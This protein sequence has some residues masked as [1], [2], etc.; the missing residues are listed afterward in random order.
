MRFYV[1]FEE[2]DV[3][4]V[5]TKYTA[6][7]NAQILI[8]LL[9]DNGIKKIVASPGTTNIA[10]V[11]SVQQDDFFEVFSAPDERSASYIACGM[12]EEAQEPVV[13][14]CTG[15]TASRNYMPGLTEAF[16]RK[17]PIIA[18][19]SSR[20]NYY[21]GQN[22]DQVTDRTVLPNDIAKVSVQLPLVHDL[23]SEWA[24]IVRGNKAMHEAIRH[25]GGPV[26]INLE[27]K[28]NLD[29]SVDKIAPVRNIEY[30]SINSQM[31]EVEVDEVG[32]VVGSHSEWS[33]ELTE[34][35]DTFCE[36]YNGAVICDPTSNYMGKYKIN[37][38]LASAQVK[39][40]SKV[41]KIAHII[42]IGG[43][44]S[45]NYRINPESVW[46]V[47]P[48]G[49]IRDTYKH[50]KAIFELDECVFFKKYIALKENLKSEMNLYKR[51]KE[52]EQEIE[53]K[54]YELPFSNAWIASNYAKKLPDNAILHLGIR[55]SLRVWSFFEMPNRVRTYSNVG[56]FGI[57]GCISS[58]IGAALVN[59]E[60]LVFCVLG[61]LAFFYDMNSLGNRHVSSN[62]RIMLVNN[63]TGMEMK[64]TGFY[65]DAIGADK[66]SYIAAS[67]HYGNKSTTLVKNYA[68]NLGFKYF[69]AKSK[70]EFEKNAEAFFSDSID[71]QPYLFE[72][73][74]NSDDED[75]AYK[76]LI[77]LE[78]S[79]MGEMK[80]TIKKVVGNTK[81]QEIKKHIQ[82]KGK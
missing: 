46:R 76:K 42:H 18:V 57:D 48:D 35:V 7:R 3:V 34:L 52:E 49:E 70:E 21:I 47:S 71:E 72:V 65:A 25:G 58:S 19:T 38:A 73:F 30:Y 59:K 14:S 17:L 63:A 80:S 23:D 62:L 37:N 40:N 33:R 8:S 29:F 10:F 82:G 39:Y 64:F 44:T 24:C 61:D 11:A 51:L 22:Y 56:G 15:A 31:P 75:E 54:R 67:N 53:S 20:Q 55:N 43:I 1:K 78:K 13:L 60:Q 69:S 50:L 36:V 81:A 27:T 12:S 66:D 45:T 26:H 16:Y 6:E 74:T 79:M 41:N 5:M 28:Y 9:K 4:I 77:N 32:I 68:E 2:G